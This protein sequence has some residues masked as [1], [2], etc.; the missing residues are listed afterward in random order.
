M[1]RSGGG[2][3]AGGML[4]IVRE[5]TK[6]TGERWGSGWGLS[7]LEETGGYAEGDSDSEEE[8]SSEVSS[9][10][11]VGWLL[12]AVEDGGIRPEDSSQYDDGGCEGDW[13]WGSDFLGVNQGIHAFLDDDRATC[14]CGPIRSSSGVRSET[15]PAE[16]AEEE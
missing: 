1:C 14:A 8:D 2:E 16:E 10:D 9:S 7:A 11:S 5:A 6:S 15:E 12:T 13:P 4:F 3:K